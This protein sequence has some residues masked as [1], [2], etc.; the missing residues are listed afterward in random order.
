MRGGHIPHLLILSL[1]LL[2][3]GCIS[4]IHQFLAGN[5]QKISFEGALERQNGNL[6][7]LDRDYEPVL[8]G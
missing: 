2:P 1:G 6:I 5:R 7:S 8:G 3:D 4:K